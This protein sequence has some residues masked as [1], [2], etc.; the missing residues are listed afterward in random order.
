MKY[1]NVTEPFIS[2]IVTNNLPPFSIRQ[3]DKFDIS[4]FS[5]I[6]LSLADIFFCILAAL[7]SISVSQALCL[8]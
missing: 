7:T 3:S 4:L 6:K 1:V 2:Y 8:K 5:S